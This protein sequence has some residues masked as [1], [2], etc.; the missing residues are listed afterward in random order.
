MPR[1]RDRLGIVYAILNIIRQ[2][3][4][5]MKYTPLL[6]KT[7]I[8]SKNFS[9]YYKE[10]IEKEFIEETFDRKKKKYIILTDKGF[11]YLEKYQYIIGF[12]DE[13]EL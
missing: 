2:N 13:F 4:N 10:L 8:S 5:S 7:N 9:E 6:R 12:I 11:Q 3:N 1:K